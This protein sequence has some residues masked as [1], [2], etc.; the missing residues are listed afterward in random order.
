VTCRDREKGDILL[1]HKLFIFKTHYERN[2][3]LGNEKSRISITYAFAFIMPMKSQEKKAVKFGLTSQIIVLISGSGYRPVYRLVEQLPFIY[4]A[5]RERG[6][7]V[8]R[9]C[10]I[11]RLSING[12][13]TGHDR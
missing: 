2:V 9:G 10:G 7:P 8:R 4:E 5:G 13:Y 3:T 1:Y 12:G 6:N 11:C